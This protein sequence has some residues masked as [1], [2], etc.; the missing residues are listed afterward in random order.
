[1]G[2]YAYIAAWHSLYFKRLQFTIF[3][4]AVWSS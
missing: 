2:N 1:V 3:I 4:K